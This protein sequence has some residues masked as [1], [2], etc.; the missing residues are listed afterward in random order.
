M[1]TFCSLIWIWTSC[2]RLVLK[3]GWWI[4]LFTSLLQFLNWHW[5]E[6]DGLRLSYFHPFCSSCCMYVTPILWQVWT[7]AEALVKSR[8]QIVSNINQISR[9]CCSHGGDILGT[10]KIAFFLLKCSFLAVQN[11]SI[12]DLVTDWLSHSLTFASDIFKIFENFE[13]F[14]QFWLCLK[15]LT[16]S[17][18][19]DNFVNFW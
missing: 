14:W 6:A 17:T 3:A 7:V 9:A 11:S 19:F 16:I 15:I 8:L 2:L 1:P 4:V 13:I 5:K 12:S 10:P 18:I